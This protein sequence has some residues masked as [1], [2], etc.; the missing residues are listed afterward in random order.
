MNIPRAIRAE[1]GWKGWTL[2]ELSEK[3]GIAQATLS[4]R[5]NGHSKFLADDLKRIAEALEL[6]MWELVRRAENEKSVA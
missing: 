5:M 2:S 4:K 6:P 1:L 3:T